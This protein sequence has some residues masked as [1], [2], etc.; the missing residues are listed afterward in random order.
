MNEG[1][2][3]GLRWMIPFDKGDPETVRR[4]IACTNEQLDLVLENGFIPYKTPVWAV[5]KLEERCRSRLPALPAGQRDDGPV[6][7]PESRQVGGTGGVNDEERH[8]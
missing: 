8:I 6:Q 5:M 2:F 3:V 1:H 4:V 7:Y